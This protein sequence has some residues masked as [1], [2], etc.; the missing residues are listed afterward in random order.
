MHK[1]VTDPAESAFIKATL[2]KAIDWYERR[3]PHLD[4]E[5][6]EDQ[7]YEYV[8]RL[9]EIHDA[10]RGETLESI[11]ALAKKYF[12]LT[13]EGTVYDGDFERWCA[14]VKNCD[15]KYMTDKQKALEELVT[16]TFLLWGSIRDCAS[17]GE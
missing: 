6:T 3:L 2:E 12:R 15:V 9:L 7:C 16:S 1:R 14:A 13:E 11:K 5:G 10:K 8:F 4:V 17:E